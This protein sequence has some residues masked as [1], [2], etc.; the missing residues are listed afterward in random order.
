MMDAM[1]SEKRPETSLSN[2]SQPEIDRRLNDIS[3]LLEN[4]WELNDFWEIHGKEIARITIRKNLKR[5]NQ[6]DLEDLV[7]ATFVRFWMSLKR[8]K[9]SFPP[10]LTTIVFFVARSVC[11]QYIKVYQT[12]SKHGF[13]I[14]YE[15]FPLIQTTPE[16][17]DIKELDLSS[18][19]TQETA[20]FEMFMSEKLNYAE[21][22]KRMGYSR[23]YIS[24]IM[25]KI[26]KKIA[27]SLGVIE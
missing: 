27:I 23:A 21:I 6:T 13:E 9:A 19:N 16:Q 8:M 25:D 11:Y 1:Y 3:R 17:V 4:E 12:R 20:V 7:Q 5:I 24:F 10:K 26:Y 22:G 15:D 18:L 14:D 2:I